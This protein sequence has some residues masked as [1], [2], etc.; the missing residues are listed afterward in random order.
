MTINNS[1]RLLLM[2]IVFM[3]IALG[4]IKTFNISLGESPESKTRVDLH[5]MNAAFGIL[6]RDNNQSLCNLIATMP[7]IN[8]SKFF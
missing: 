4:I 3:A 5:C 6:L 7:D 8:A 1:C 2:V